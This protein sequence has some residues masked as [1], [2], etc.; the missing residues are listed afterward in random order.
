MSPTTVLGSWSFVFYSSVSF[1]IALIVVILLA[2]LLPSN[3]R[4]RSWLLLVCS[5]V[6][7]LAI[8]QFSLGDLFL[9]WGMATVSFGVSHILSWP[10]GVWSEGLRPWL[11][12]FGVL[13]VLGFLAVFKYGFIQDFLWAPREHA[14]STNYLSLLGVSYFSFK[15]IQVIVDSLNGSVARFDALTYFNFITFFPAFIS[16]PISRYNQF[17]EQLS[18]DKRGTIRVDLKL[19]AERI[20]H[21]LFKKFVLVQL[22]FPYAIVSQATPLAQQSTWQ[23]LLGLYA[24]ALYLY[25]D[26]SGYSDMAIG[27]ARLIGI[28]LPENFN[29]P[30]LQKNIREFWGSWH[31][32]LTS[33]LVDYVYWPIVRKL[34]N[35]QYF[36]VRPVLLSIV[37]M[38]A[39]FVAVGAWHGE[40]LNFILWGV[41]HGIGI[42]AVNVYQ[43]QKRRIR[44]KRVQ[45]YF[46][47]RMSQVVG[48]ISTFHF[49]IF[50]L[51][52]FALNMEKLRIL[53]SRLAG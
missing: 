24:Y 25:F 21:G 53:F 30:F 44:N 43:R 2:R 35:L 3:P 27:A 46:A 37:G 41:Y 9:V 14:P 7:L 38:N 51:A 52:L 33:W 10:K 12:A 23:I 18:A 20:V 22:F 28:E 8:P 11:A 40:A 50:G 5:S 47:S 16:G 39:T 32:S 1:W 4:A 42:S 36:R 13:A 26:F 19:G 48:I 15:A 29:W 6:L 17:A 49:F 34:R 45:R 31:M